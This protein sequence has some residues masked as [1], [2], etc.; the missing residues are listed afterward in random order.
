M[1][2]RVYVCIHIYIYHVVI[3]I[4]ASPCPELRCQRVCDEYRED[5]RTGCKTCAC[6]GNQILNTHVRSHS[7]KVYIY[8][9]IYM[10]I[11][12]HTHIG[13]DYYLIRS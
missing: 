6:E 7:K 8:V 9:H 2:V 1:C 3:M 4:A 11:C 5:P 10:H 12:I 13:F